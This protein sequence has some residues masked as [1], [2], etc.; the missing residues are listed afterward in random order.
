MRSALPQTQAVLDH[1][2]LQEFL[3]ENIYAEADILYNT[4]ADDLIEYCFRQYYVF[5]FGSHPVASWYKQFQQDAY[6]ILALRGY[7]PDETEYWLRSRRFVLYAQSLLSGLKN[8]SYVSHPDAS[9]S[10]EDLT[11]VC[12]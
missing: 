8:E 4:D 1:Q 9:S 10:G 5:L 12:P 7:L 6:R 2:L 11:H 3:C